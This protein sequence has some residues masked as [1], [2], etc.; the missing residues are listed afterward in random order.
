MSVKLS[1]KNENRDIQNYETLVTLR[2]SLRSFLE[3]LHIVIGRLTRV[4]GSLSW[5]PNT[6][7]AEEC[8]L[9]IEIALEDLEKIKTLLEG[10]IS[11]PNSTKKNFIEDSFPSMHT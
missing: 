3:E 5:P 10:L 8:L 7:A 1:S 2:T 6:K 9:S 11:S 4:D